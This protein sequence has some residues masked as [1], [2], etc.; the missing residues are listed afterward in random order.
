MYSIVTQNA[1]SGPP[2]SA[3]TLGVLFTTSATSF[4]TSRLSVQRWFLHLIEILLKISN[5]NINTLIPES[6][7]HCSILG[8]ID[9]R[10][11][12]ANDKTKESTTFLVVGII[13]AVVVVIGIFGGAVAFCCCAGRSEEMEK[14]VESQ[15]TSVIVEVCGN[16]SQA[17]ILVQAKSTSACVYVCMCMYVCVHACAYVRIVCACVHRRVYVHRLPSS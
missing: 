16:D 2:S 3:S 6:W 4:T 1:D 14:Q 12:A 7:C 8:N 17:R 9:G 5:T 15:K 13:I 11:A 10:E